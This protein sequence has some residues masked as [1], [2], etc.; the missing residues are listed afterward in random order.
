MSLKT[1][2]LL[3]LFCAMA[4]WAEAQSVDWQIL[5]H[6]LFHA[7]FQK[8]KFEQKREVHFIHFKSHN[9]LIRYNP[10]SLTFGGLLYFYQTTFSQ[11]F[12]SDCPFEISC[13]A[14]S[15]LSIQQ[16][17]LIKGVALTADRLMRCNQFLKYDITP[18]QLNAQ[19][20]IIDFPTD[21]SFKKKWNKR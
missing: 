18:F 20:R 4:S 16:L 3:W 2:I 14:Y 12:A 13:S 19:Q 1:K 15:K 6:Q 8:K 7:D 5:D 17:G 10:I 11:Q 9:V 21:Y